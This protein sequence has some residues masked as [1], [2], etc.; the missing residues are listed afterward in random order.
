MDSRRAE[1]RGLRLGDRRAHGN[2]AR[3][4]RKLS[5]KGTLEAGMIKGWRPEDGPFHS[6][7]EDRQGHRISE[8]IEMFQPAGLDRRY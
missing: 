5:K 6:H 7:I 1:Y 3:I 2:P 4:D 8:S